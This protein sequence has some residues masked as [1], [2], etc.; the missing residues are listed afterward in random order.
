MHCTHGLNRTGY[1]I[2]RYLIEVDGW[3]ANS[4]IERM[5]YKFCFILDESGY[6]TRCYAVANLLLLAVSS[7][8]FLI[9]PYLNLFIFSL[10]FEYCRGYKIERMKYI[11]S[12]RNDCIRGKHAILSVEYPGKSFNKMPD[13]RLPHLKKVLPCFDLNEFV[14]T[15]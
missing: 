2:C 13:K 8:H 15:N 11:D 3:D 1:M 9:S 6:S 10:E 12:L 7:V 4:A 5:F 14:A